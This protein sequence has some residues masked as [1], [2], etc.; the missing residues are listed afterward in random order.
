MPAH[1]FISYSNQD[2]NQCQ[3]VIKALMSN[4]ITAWRDSDFIRP[5][6]VFW[7]EIENAI[8]NSGCALVILS[9]TAE[10]SE[11][12]R[13]EVDYAILRQV[14]VIPL[15]FRIGIADLSE[16]WV[17]RIGHFQAIHQ[18]DRF[19]KAIRDQVLSAVREHIHRVCRVLA[20]LNMKGG[21]GKTMMTAQLGIR[22][23][24]LLKKN[25]LL[26]DLDPQQ[27]LTELF[28]PTKE[29]AELHR[30]HRSIIGLF[31]PQKINRDLAERYDFECDC[32]AGLD[33]EPNYL[34]LCF[35]TAAASGG[36]RLDILP[37][38]FQAVKYIKLQS[39]EREIAVRNFKRG[40][41]ALRQHYDYIFI[42]CNPAASFLSEAALNGVDHLLCP[43]RPDNSAPRGLYFLSESMTRLFSLDTVP[44]MH[45]AFNFV[46]D[47]MKAETNLMTW[48]REGNEKQLNPY[49]RRFVGKYLDTGVHESDAL[50]SR[51]AAASKFLT[52]L[53]PGYRAYQDLDKLALDL[54]KR[55]EK[56][57]SDAEECN[58][59]PG[60]ASSVQG[61]AEVVS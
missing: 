41:S 39:G 21:V 15:L 52:R 2:S 12:V 42:D 1:V 36:K 14:P 6:H 35:S 54:T 22:I 18:E 7:D 57:T 31:E 28:V 10:Q 59:G 8:K 56:G 5:G 30:S 37:S 16:W 20:V 33:H 3:R 50:R 43:V 29:L 58:R 4:G 25:V 46:N 11:N 9:S 44:E 27:N 13:R 47:K 55:I 45:I 53:R 40:L 19:V 32:V 38:Q 49:Y 34:D 24:S 23:H 60:E 51:Y 61:Q 17:N 26:I 48:L